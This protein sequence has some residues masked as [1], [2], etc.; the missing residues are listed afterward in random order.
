MGDLP[1]STEEANY[2][3]RSFE[4][5]KGECDALIFVQVRYCFIARS[6]HI[7]VPAG[8]LSHEIEGRSSCIEGLVLVILTC[9]F[10]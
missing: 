1:T 10:A 8:I 7:C 6:R 5:Y 4:R 2:T 9:N 3:R